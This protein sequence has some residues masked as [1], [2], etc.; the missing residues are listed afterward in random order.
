MLK[1][2]MNNYPGT[3]EDAAYA[4]NVA[5]RTLAKYL[6]EDRAP[7]EVVIGISEI[8]NTPELPLMYCAA[9]CPIGRNFIPQVE[10]LDCPQATLRVMSELRDV[11]EQQ[12]EM[13]AIHRDGQL[14]EDEIP[15]QEAI[16]KEMTESIQAM[17]TY[18]VNARREITKIKRAGSITRQKK[19]TA[20]YVVAVG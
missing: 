3:Q 4:L 12:A 1:E 19:R 15:I 2:C 17:Q 7:A 14:T 5:P 11:V 10:R 16:I 8:C 20:A 9:R 13:V 6:A 18:I